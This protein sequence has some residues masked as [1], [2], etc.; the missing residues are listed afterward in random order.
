M[1]VNDISGLP[2]L[3]VFS[4]DRVVMGTFNRN[5]LV[6]TGSRVGIGKSV[7]STT[8]D[9]SGSATVTGSLNVFSGSIT[10]SGPQN[11]FTTVNS[12]GT[13]TGYIKSVD[14]V[15][16]EMGS[17]DQSVYLRASNQTIAQVSTIGFISPADLGTSLGTSTNRWKNLVVGSVT[18][19][20]VSASFTG[21]LLG[22]AAFAQTASYF[23]GSITFPNGLIVT[24]GLQ[25]TSISASSGII[26][27]LIGTSSWASNAV[28]SSYAFTASQAISGSFATTSSF[29]V[30]ASWA[31]SAGG[32]ITS[33]TAGDGLT[34]GTITSTGTITVDTGSVHFLDG[35]KKELNTE[36]VISSSTQVNYIQLQNI[37]TGIVSSSS[38]INTG[39][40][41]GSFTGSLLGTSSIAVTAQTASYFDGFITF[42]SGLDI[43]GSLVVTGSQRTIGNQ[44]ITG[45]LILSSSAPVE[46]QV[47]GNSE[48]TGSL[49]VNGNPISVLSSSITS[50]G[51]QGAVLL[52]TGPSQLI[53]FYENGSYIYRGVTANHIFRVNSTNAISIDTSGMGPVN[54]NV[55]GLG[56]STNR[57]ASAHINSIISSGSNQHTGSIGVLSGSITVTNGGVTSSLFGTSSFATTASFAVSA[58]WAPSTGGPGGLT[59]KAGSIAN[60]SFTGN[61][62]K[63]PVNFSTAFSNTNYAV[64]ITGEDARSW[65]VEGKVV[66]GFTASANSNTGLAGTTYWVATA[67]GES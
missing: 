49:Q 38:Q 42:P 3:E 46:L 55:Y 26:G 6:V 65:T 4:D 21:S 48:I 33:L 35:V 19:S 51:P 58:S 64:V 29:A 56:G 61:P 62:R 22:T 52:N 9:I 13:V 32:G 43:T 66:G 34:G 17:R 16:V 50:S 57:F 27:N 41:T 40:F 14:G 45:S 37:P 5:A 60:T 15:G 36:T 31:P 20:V 28:T 10:S 25:V 8:L 1:S 59:T 18:A 63:A 11:E 44:E 2:I 24:G 54:N 30:S 53:L 7:P 47:I 39:S 12:A 23:S 67:Y